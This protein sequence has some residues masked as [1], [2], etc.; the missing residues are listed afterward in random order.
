MQQAFNPKQISLGIK[1]Q[2]LCNTKSHHTHLET[3]GARAPVLSAWVSGRGTHATLTPKSGEK[4]NVLATLLPPGS[5]EEPPPLFQGSS[6]CLLGQAPICQSEC[7]HAYSA[8]HRTSQS[9]AQQQR[10]LFQ[11]WLQEPSKR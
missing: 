8:S 1:K 11:H 4:G 7:S 10:S 6:W 5:T 3:K 2:N 9:E